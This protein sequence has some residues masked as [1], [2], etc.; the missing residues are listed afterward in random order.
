LTSDFR[1]AVASAAIDEPLAGTASTVRAFLLLEHPG[2]WGVEALRDAR[3]PSSVGPRLARRCH[4]AGVRP[5][6]IRRHG[7]S[8]SGSVRC[9]AAYP[10]RR[11]ETATFTSVEEVLEIDVGALGR[12]DPVGLDAHAEPLFLV[13][14]HGRHDVCCAERGRPLAAA[15][16]AS[17]PRH[18]WECSHI[19][20]DRFA[21]NVL[22]LPDGLYYGRVEAEAGPALAGRHLAGQLDLD[23]LRGRTMYGFAL[24]AAE[25]HLRRRLGVTGLDAVSLQGRTVDG[26]I[27]TAV[28][29]VQGQ[30]WRVLVRCTPGE[31]A[32]LTCAA[33][34]LRRALQLHLLDV[35]PV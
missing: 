20:G 18:T 16:T 12:G 35:E 28:F 11:L 27:T 10:G 6:L 19:G 5:L 29:E 15:M 9:F 4:E 26:D 8:A 1:C 21:G 30:R 22:V 3:L 31:P 7:R 25:W 32:R 34:A 2:S 14:T 17:H 33:G 23:R 24:Q 13:C